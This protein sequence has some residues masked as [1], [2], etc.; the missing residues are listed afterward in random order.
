MEESKPRL[1]RSF[2]KNGSVATPNT[3]K[4]NSYSNGYSLS[5]YISEYKDAF[6]E[7]TGRSANVSGV[8][9]E[10]KADDQMNEIGIAAN[11]QGVCF[12]DADTIWLRKSQWDL[13]DD[14]E[15]RALVFHEYGHC[16][17]K[18]PHKSTYYNGHKLSLLHPIGSFPMYERYTWEYDEELF[19]EDESHLR[20]VL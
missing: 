15:R 1:K 2:G 10:V 18:R 5:H 16:H 20:Q 11:A 9:I 13:M 12:E 17:L 19:N 8:K 6:L 3:P 7:H 14:F 4:T